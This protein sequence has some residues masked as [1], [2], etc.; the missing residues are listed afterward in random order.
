[1]TVVSIVTQDAEQWRNIAT[2]LARALCW[3][4]GSVDFGPGGR[5]EAGWVQLAR[6][7]INR[8]HDLIDVTNNPL[9]ELA[10]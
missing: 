7:A 10:P 3:T 5:A 4:S 2:E 8:Y 6:P 9:W 1:M